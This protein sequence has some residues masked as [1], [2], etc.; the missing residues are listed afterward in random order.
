MNYRISDVSELAPALAACRTAGDA[1]NTI[2]FADGEYFL[3]EPIQLDERDSGLTLAGSG[4]TT[5]CG[6][7]R[8]AGWRR[9][10]DLLRVD[11]PS[12]AEPRLLVMGGTSRKRARFPARSVLENRDMP[13][14]LRWMS[15]TGGGWSRPLTHDELIHMSVD[16]GD[17]PP[18]MDLPNA[19][20]TV[21][22]KWDESTVRVKSYDAA[23]GRVE[24]LTETLRPP[25]SFQNH[26]YTVWNTREGLTE[27][28]Q[29]Y[30]DRS[31]EQ[32]VYLPLPGEEPDALD[33]WIPLAGEHLVLCERCRNVEIRDLRIRLCHARAE[34]AGLRALNVPGAVE[35]R[36]AEAARVESVAVEHVTGN[37]I[38]LMRCRDL[39]VRHCRVREAGAGGIFTYECENEAITR[40][41]VTGIGRTTFSAIGIHCGWKSMLPYVLAGYP[42]E[43]G[44]VLLAH[45][46]IE[47]VPYCGIT[48]NGGP[49]R[50]EYNRLS[51]CMTGLRDGAAIYCSRGDRT[52]MRGNHVLDIDSDLAYAYYFDEQSRHCVLDANIAVDVPRPIL[53]HMS[54]DMLICRNVFLSGK[55]CVIN[56]ARSRYTVWRHNVVAC[57]GKLAFTHKGRDYRDSTIPTQTVFAFIGCIVHSRSGEIAVMGNS[58]LPPDNAL[59]CADPLLSID[60]TGGITVGTNSPAIEMGL[61]LPDGRFAGAD[62][63]EPEPERVE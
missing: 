44:T 63:P 19:E 56:M 14:N 51:R 50:I 3:S 23:D 46:T 2:E 6:G 55:G 9:D 52:I 17:I 20:I 60:A 39:V 33:G 16:S 30:F 18:G 24:F 48:C 25:G 35:I 15:S 49:H 59:L 62:A 41:T 29:W 38:K 45:N 12:G 27:P 43:R 28:G 11:V 61:R 37:G 26:G 5:L 58:Q 4:A 42:E 53:F 40:N 8:L 7:C 47:D 54:E 34:V 22:H 57:D 21:Y 32:I 13:E 36:D 1:R 31:L 10:G